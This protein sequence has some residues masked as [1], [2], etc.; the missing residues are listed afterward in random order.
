[1]DLYNSCSVR[2]L[3]SEKSYWKKLS[4]LGI[5]KRTEGDIAFLEFDIEQWNKNVY[6]AAEGSAG[7]HPRWKETPVAN[8]PDFYVHFGL[9]ATTIA[10]QTAPNSPWA[11]ATEEATTSSPAQTHLAISTPGAAETGAF[12]AAALSTQNMAKK[13]KNTVASKVHPKRKKREAAAA[14]AS[15][16]NIVDVNNNLDV[17][18]LDYFSNADIQEINANMNYIQDMYMN[19]DMTYIKDMKCIETIVMLKSDYSTTSVADDDSWKGFLSSG[20]LD[21]LF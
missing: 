18:R 3:G 1:M 19:Y 7:S 4:E 11:G 8:V 5:S 16:I 21:Y 17:L 13:R 2:P 20:I 14:G 15:E 10:P 9:P 12:V 6:R